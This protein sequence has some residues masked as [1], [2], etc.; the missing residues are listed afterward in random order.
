MF[1]KE[2]LRYRPD[3]PS[4]QDV[5]RSMNEEYEG[6]LGL[7]FGVALGHA[8]YT[9]LGPNQTRLTVDSDNFRVVVGDDLHRHDDLLM[10]E[11]GEDE[12]EAR[13]IYRKFGHPDCEEVSESDEKLVR[14][15]DSTL[16]APE[17]VNKLDTRPYSVYTLRRGI[18]EIYDNA[19]DEPE[20]S[21][22]NLI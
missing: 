17:H 18:E 9:W 1:E 7:D 3:F 5:E 22:E 20:I 21:R 4:V 13:L 10:D 8:P 11:V 14:L 16:G 15:V 2:V 12:L 19:V 6:D